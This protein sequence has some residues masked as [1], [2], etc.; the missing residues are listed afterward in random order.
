MVWTGGGTVSGPITGAAGTTLE[1]DGPTWTFNSN[2]SI[3][4]DDRVVFSQYGEVATVSGS[5]NVATQTYLYATSLTFTTAIIN[6]GTDL[7]INNSNL[8]LTGQSF[9]LATVEFYGGGLNGMGGASLTVTDS[10]DWIGGTLTGFGALEI[11]QTATLLLSSGA[12]S[13]TLDGVELQNAGAA[14]LSLGNFCCGPIG[15]VLVNGAGVDNQST[16]SFAFESNGGTPLISTDPSATY[17]DNEG[18]ITVDV[19]PTYGAD[20]TRVH[21]E[22][23]RHHVRQFRRDGP[24]RRRR[25]DHDRRAGH[26]CI[27]RGARGRFRL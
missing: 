2:S 17:F 23:H 6:L 19:T 22:R 1:F 5:Y 16:G 15:L 10:I 14:S 8:N 21:A 12:N 27:R 3:T 11:P 7:S 24:A 9:S 25:A 4:S 13:E 20:P 18:S 26:D